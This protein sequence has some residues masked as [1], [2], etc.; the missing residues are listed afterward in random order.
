MFV[1]IRN[2]SIDSR[3][4]YRFDAFG[5]GGHCPHRKTFEDDRIARCDVSRR[6]LNSWCILQKHAFAIFHAI[7]PVIVSFRCVFNRLRPSTLIRCI[8]VSV[9]IH[10]QELNTLNTLSYNVN[11]RILIIRI[12]LKTLL[13]SIRAINYHLCKNLFRLTWETQLLCGL[14][15]FTLF[16]FFYIMPFSPF[17][18]CR[19]ENNLYLETSC[20]G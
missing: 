11:V 19:I 13:A 16:L 17:C 12:F 3:P 5:G 15:F 9:L 1:V 2:A 10:F 6:N 4:H 20:R 14:R 18:T 8:C 7:F